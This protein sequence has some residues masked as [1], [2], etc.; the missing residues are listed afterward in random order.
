MRAA[1]ERS[2]QDRVTGLRHRLGTVHDRDT[3]LVAQL[4]GIARHAAD[5][6]RDIRRAA[7]PRRGH[8]RSFQRLLGGGI[9]ERLGE[10]D[11]MIIRH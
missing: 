5:A 8:P 3:P 2:Q 10:D 6:R 4:G 1:V 9:I 11:H 7:W